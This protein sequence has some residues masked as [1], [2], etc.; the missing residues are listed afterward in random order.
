MIVIEIIWYLIFTVLSLFILAA[1][2][3]LLRI[4]IQWWLDVDYIEMIKRW[5][6]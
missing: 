5:R 2:L 6:K 1:C 3:W 4:T